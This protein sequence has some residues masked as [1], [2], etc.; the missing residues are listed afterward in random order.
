MRMRTPLLFAIGLT[1]MAASAE[2]LDVI[3]ATLK[4]GCSVP[5]YVAIKNDFNQQ[6]GK[7]HSY[8][9]E[10]LV[11]LQSDDLAAVYWV[12]RS[13]SVEA[14]GKAWDAWRT[15]SADPDTVAGQLW[16]RFVKCSENVTRRGYDV[17]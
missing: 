4:E 5:T 3:K 13:A 2:H 12:G 1:P 10:I 7:G 8:H 16:G 11:P 15:E 9:A 6:W 17:Y 14:F